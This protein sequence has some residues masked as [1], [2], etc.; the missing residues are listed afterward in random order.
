MYFEKTRKH[1]YLGKYSQVC[2]NMPK[3]FYLIQLT[4]ADNQPASLLVRPLSKLPVLFYC[5]R[6]VL[7][8]P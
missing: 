4:S 3:Y 6:F 7:A 5:Q 8:V 2:V 1:F